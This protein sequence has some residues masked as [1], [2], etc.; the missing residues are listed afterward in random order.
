MFKLFGS[1][2]VGKTTALQEERS[3]RVCRKNEV[4]ESL[5]EDKPHFGHFRGLGTIPRPIWEGWGYTFHL[6]TSPCGYTFHLDTL[7]RSIWIHYDVPS[8]Y[9]WRYTFH[10]DTRSIWIRLE[11]HVPSGYIYDDFR[12]LEIHAPSGY[13][14][15]IHVPKSREFPS[16]RTLFFFED[17]RGLGTINL[18]S[19]HLPRRSFTCKVSLRFEAVC[20]PY[21]ALGFEQSSG[22]E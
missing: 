9:E 21:S 6:D 2:P 4:R 18:A 20:V 3:P 22:D 10:L 11:I 15:E 13:S 8:G 19:P 5:Q 16:G 1:N 12:G 14:V 17:F 7:R